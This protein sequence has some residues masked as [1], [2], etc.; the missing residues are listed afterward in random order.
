MTNILR[1]FSFTTAYLQKLLALVM[2]F[3]LAALAD[4]ALL[5][6]GSSSCSRFLGHALHQTLLLIDYIPFLG[7]LYNATYA[8]NL[9]FS[10]WP[11]K[12]SKT[13][14]EGDEEEEDENSEGSEV[15]QSSSLDQLEKSR[16]IRVKGLTAVAT[17]LIDL[18]TLCLAVGVIAYVCDCLVRLNTF[19]LIRYLLVLFILFTALALTVGLK[20]ITGQAVDH[21]TR[22]LEDVTSVSTSMVKSASIT[23]LAIEKIVETTNR[24]TSALVDLVTAWWAELVSRVL[25]VV[26]FPRDCYRSVEFKFKRQVARY[27]RAVRKVKLQVRK[28]VM[29]VT[30]VVPPVFRGVLLISRRGGQMDEKKL[31]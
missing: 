23:V 20:I 7:P 21:L 24:Q 31:Q 15:H 12:A 19:A 26:F 25:A 13:F 16:L 27:R 8:L 1:E 22:Q 18:L 10:F 14:D 6:P 3:D 4:R 17:A 30:E 2:A 28:V 29:G 9:L 11:A 5:G